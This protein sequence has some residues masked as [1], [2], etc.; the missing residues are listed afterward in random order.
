MRKCKF[1]GKEF[2]PKEIP[3]GAPEQEY[4]TIKCRTKMN[5]LN[6]LTRQHN[7]NQPKQP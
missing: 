4:C 6:Y 5:S 7:A 3:Q 1:C 2:Q